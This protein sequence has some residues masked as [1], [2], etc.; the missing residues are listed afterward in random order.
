MPTAGATSPPDEGGV[1]AAKAA[2]AELITRYAALIDAG[3]WDAVA[4]L[5]TDDGRMNRPSAPEDFICGRGAILAALRSRPQRLARH[6]V[7]NVLVTLESGTRARATSQILLFGAT[8]A[9]GGGLPVLWAGPPL[10]GS[11]SDSLVRTA[12]GWRFAE[13]RGSMDFRAPLPG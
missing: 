9:E 4:A 11:Y 6:I 3:D 5:Y 8:A 10:V 7:A 1:F 13:R 12:H 2:I